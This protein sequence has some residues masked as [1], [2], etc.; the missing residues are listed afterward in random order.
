MQTPGL[1]IMHFD[2]IYAGVNRMCGT[3]GGLNFCV[4][5]NGHGQLGD[6]TQTSRSVPT[7]AKVFRYY[8]PTVF[9]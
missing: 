1:A 9:Y 7:E 4:G 3:T 2:F 8:H 5:Y 6:G